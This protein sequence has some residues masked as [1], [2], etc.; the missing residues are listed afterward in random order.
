MFWKRKAKCPVTEEDKVWVEE[1]LDWFQTN[2]ID[3]CEQPTFTPTKKY[4]PYDFRGTEEDAEFIL[5]ILGD[6]FQ[7]NTRRI[8]LDFYDQSHTDLGMGMSTQRE[9]KGAVGLY[10]QDGEENS[11]LIEVGQLKDTT[12]LIATIAHELSHYLIMEEKGYYFEETENE[13]LTDMAV[14]AYGF[15]IFLGNSKFKFKQWSS[16]DGWGGWS[17]S[18]QGYLP[19]QIIAYTMAEIQRRKND[20]EPEWTTHMERNLKSYFNKSIRYI[21]EN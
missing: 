18:A 14:I 20:L 12:S 11:I 2:F 21:Q 13:F 4:F 8:Y 15:G 19:Q 9:S 3:V 1:K 16:G 7:L 10:L 17:A 5:D 6:Y